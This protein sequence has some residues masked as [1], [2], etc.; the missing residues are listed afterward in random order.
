MVMVWRFNSVDKTG[1]GEWRG[2]EVTGKGK[3]KN[4]S[5]KRECQY[6]LLLTLL[7]LD[8]CQPLGPGVLPATRSDLVV[9]R[10]TVH[11]TVPA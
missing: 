1:A 7:L 11:S 6:H 3:D 10:V 9:P 8:R 4:T 2:K 5:L